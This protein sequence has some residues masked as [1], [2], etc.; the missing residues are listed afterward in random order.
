MRREWE[1]GVHRIL[2]FSFQIM[3]LLDFLKVSDQNLI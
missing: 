3:T 2:Q 1:M